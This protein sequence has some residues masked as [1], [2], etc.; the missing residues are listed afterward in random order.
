MRLALWLLPAAVLLTMPASAR[1]APPLGRDLALERVEVRDDGSGVR[2]LRVVRRVR[3]DRAGRGYVATMMVDPTR[4]E[5][6]KGEQ[7]GYVALVRAL[8]TPI[9]VELDAGGH[10][11]RVRDADGA[12]AKLR[13]VIAGPMPD[14]ARGAALRLHDA[15][16][17]AERDAALAGPLLAVLAGDEAERAPGV[18]A[19]TLPAAGSGNGWLS[20]TERTARQGDRIVLETDASGTVDTAHGAAEVT[21]FRRRAVDRRTGLAS[22]TVEKRTSTAAAGGVLRNEVTVTLKPAVS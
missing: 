6:S 10:L 12:W 14:A 19:V 17:G 15:T 5:D 21:L 2:R 16:G 4:V 11:L 13:A 9:A 1:F 18:R 22:D 8:S 7:A 3:F 20:G